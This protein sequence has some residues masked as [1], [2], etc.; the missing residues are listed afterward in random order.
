MLIQPLVRREAVLSSRIE[1]TQTTLGELLAAEAGTIVERSPSDV[2]E[3]GNYVAALNH[4]IRRLD[5]LPLSRRLV[6][7][8]HEKLMNGVRGNAATPGQFRRTQ[9]WIGPAGCTLSNA[10][11]VPPPADQLMECLGA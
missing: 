8:L 5:T 4:G 11:Y 6:K 3:V 1:G 10:T 7:E 9:N 2:R